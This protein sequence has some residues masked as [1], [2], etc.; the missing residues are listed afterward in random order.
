MYEDRIAKNQE[1][2]KK[3]DEQIL[4]STEKRKKLADET[5]R[6]VCLSLCSEYRCESKDLLDIIR[7]E[8]QQNENPD[9]ANV[10]KRLKLYASCVIIKPKRIFIAA[11]LRKE[12][13]C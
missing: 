3:L 12:K 6:L 5:T 4:R 1:K 8:H 13:K 7:S 10:R 9:D 2:I 11:L